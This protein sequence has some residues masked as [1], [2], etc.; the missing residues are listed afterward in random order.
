MK[1]RLAAELTAARN[2]T[3][4]ASGAQQ[5]E[6]RLRRVLELV[7]VH[8]RPHPLVLGARLGDVAQQPETSK[9]VGFSVALYGQELQPTSLLPSCRE[10]L[11]GGAGLIF[12]EIAYQPAILHAGLQNQLTS[13]HLKSNRLEP[14]EPAGEG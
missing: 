4:L 14:A 2:Y 9:V 11:G 7:D 5:C 1:V 10:G 3:L 8:V 6:L 13:A 12:F